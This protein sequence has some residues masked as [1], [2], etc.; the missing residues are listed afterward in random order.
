MGKKHSKS[1]GGSFR[2]LK[3]GEAP[4]AV[5]KKMEEL[6]ILEEQKKENTEEAISARL[7]EFVNVQKEYHNSVYAV[8][9]IGAELAEFIKQLKKSSH[10][11][12]TTNKIVSPREIKWN[13]MIMPDDVLKPRI[14]LQNIKYKEGIS[15][16]KYTEKALKN[17]EHTKH[18]WLCQ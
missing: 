5:Q 9:V 6:K 17:Y 3:P 14:G 18:D 11:E 15:T 1:K 12:K 7:K 4:A 16:L 10:P 13:G 8:A 2:T